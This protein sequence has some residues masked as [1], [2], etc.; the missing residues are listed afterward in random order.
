[1]LINFIDL[2]NGINK[3]KLLI[4]GDLLRGISALKIGFQIMAKYLNKEDSLMME[5]GR[6]SWAVVV[7]KSCG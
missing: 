7:C 6:P 1:M 2:E 4:E 3:V 5:D